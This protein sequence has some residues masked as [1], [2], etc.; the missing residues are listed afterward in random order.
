MKMKKTKNSITSAMSNTTYTNTF[1]PNTI[2][3]TTTGTSTSY[4]TLTPNYNNL[5]ISPSFQPSAFSLSFSWDDRTVNI[6]LKKGNDVFKLAKAF[7]KMLDNE[8]IEYDIKTNK[9]RR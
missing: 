1:N 9:K 4:T 8:G 2:T 3:T 7:M 6:S 5:T